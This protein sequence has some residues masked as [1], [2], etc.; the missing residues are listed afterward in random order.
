MKK[1]FIFDMD[2]VLIDSEPLWEQAEL[3]ILHR[4]G[5]PIRR[6]ELAAAVGLPSK[7]IIRYAGEL[8]DTPV[9]VEAISNE[10]L[11]YA[12]AQILQ[13]KPLMAGVKQTLELLAANG[14]KL[15]IASASPR[16]MLET[17]VESCGIAHYFDYIASAAEL[18]YNKPHP[19][20]Y[21]QAARGLGALP[22]M[23]V[24]I[25]DSKVGMTAVK[26][27]SMSCIVIPTAQDFDGPYWALADVKLNNLLEINQTLIESL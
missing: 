15:A 10:L 11:D 21:L 3:D 8:Y 4:H 13:A 6:E 17:I 23:C 12:I 20:V 25:E 16:Y 14:V 5:I 24:G 2:G 18:A 26:A 7:S 27:A 9:D 19:E 22:S 1:A